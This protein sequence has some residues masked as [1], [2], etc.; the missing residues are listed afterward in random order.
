MRFLASSIGLLF[1]LFLVGCGNFWDEENPPEVKDDIQIENVARREVLLES[2][3]LTNQVSLGQHEAGNTIELYLVGTRYTLQF[4]NIIDRNYQSRWTTRV[5]I[6]DPICRMCLTPKLMECFENE[7]RG[8]CTHKYREQMDNVKSPYLFDED[9]KNI[10]V[11]FRIGNN[12]YPIGV[13]SDHQGAKIVSRFK[14]SN[15]MLSESNEVFLIITPEP[16][17][18]NV[19]TGFLG[20]GRCEGQGQ[21]SFSSGGPT[22]SRQIPNQDKVEFKASVVVEY[23]R[24][25]K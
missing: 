15:E 2:E 8:T 4:T 20:F 6:R 14:L 17:N 25:A 24:E 22:G 21:R 23:P 19:Q 10:S 1:M 9:A 11:K 13:I 18:G 7:Y 16:V 3:I 5:C 12:T